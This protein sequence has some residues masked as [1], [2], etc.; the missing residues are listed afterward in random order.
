MTVPDDSSD[1]ADP[2][3]AL[4]DA[5]GPHPSASS[6]GPPPRPKKAPPPTRPN[7]AAVASLVLGVSAWVLPVV[8]YLW[9]VAC[10]GIVVE[11]V[12]LAT[13]GFYGIVGLQ[14]ARQCRSG[15]G[16]AMAGTF[17]GIIP[18]ALVILLYYYRFGRVI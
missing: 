1:P 18:M 11:M 15:R 16:M 7:K 3:R 4:Q 17:L 2:L 6:S 10:L 5:A 8:M 12:I 13:A 14:Q 9:P